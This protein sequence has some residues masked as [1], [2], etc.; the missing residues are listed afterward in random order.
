MWGQYVSKLGLLLWLS[1]SYGNIRR[2]V[3]VRGRGT[4]KS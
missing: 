4:G 1:N 3:K 2:A